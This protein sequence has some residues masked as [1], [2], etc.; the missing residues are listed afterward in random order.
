MTD[1]SRPPSLAGVHDLR[2]DDGSTSA[3]VAYHGKHGTGR[4]WACWLP[5][6]ASGQHGLTSDDGSPVLAID[7]DF[8]RVAERFRIHVW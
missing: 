3:G 8:L 4:C 2:L 7:D 1:T 6:G 5:G